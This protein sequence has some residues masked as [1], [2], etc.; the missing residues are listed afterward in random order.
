MGDSHCD[1]YTEDD[2]D[3]EEEAWREQ[4]ISDWERRA[5]EVLEELKTA[6]HPKVWGCCPR[7]TLPG[8]KHYPSC[9]IG[10]VVSLL[11]S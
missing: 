11:E 10:K 9:L 4:M 5:R 2:W 1:Y 8:G 7:C 6:Y 3:A